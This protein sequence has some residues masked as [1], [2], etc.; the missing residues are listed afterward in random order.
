MRDMASS[1]DDY[2]N[3][4]RAEAKALPEYGIARPPARSHVQSKYMPKRA[5]LD[6]GDPDRW[7]KANWSDWF[8][9]KLDQL[10]ESV[11]T[12][13]KPV[14]G[15]SIEWSRLFRSEKATTNML[16]QLDCVSTNRGLDILTE[17][18]LD[19]DWED[20]MGEWLWSLL[21]RLDCP[22][23]ADRGASLAELGR[24]LLEL[25][26]IAPIEQVGTFNMLICVIAHVFGQK[27]LLRVG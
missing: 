11:A 9:F 7:P 12:R 19:C 24:R 3:S 17:L 25:R 26:N 22:I 20:W 1:V 8:A 5:D 18:I 4:V 23:D 10:R 16:C 6:F 15:D 27:Q 14:Q 21:M 2:L 13:V